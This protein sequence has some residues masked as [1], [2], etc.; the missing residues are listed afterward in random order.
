MSNSFASGMAP[1]H[2]KPT[3]GSHVR[4]QYHRRKSPLK[5]VLCGE[6][7]RGEL[8][9]GFTKWLPPPKATTLVSQGP[10]RAHCSCLVCITPTFRS[11]RLVG[12]NVCR[13][14]VYIGRRA[15]KKDA[16]YSGASCTHH[17]EQQDGPAGVAGGSEQGS[18]AGGGSGGQSHCGTRL[19]VA[20]RPQSLETY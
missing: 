20:Q 12:G 15:L 13:G 14:L 9:S 4:A 6:L 5:D 16:P 1:S 3:D 19:P 11:G 18:G 2:A 7:R 8:Q 17:T 10:T